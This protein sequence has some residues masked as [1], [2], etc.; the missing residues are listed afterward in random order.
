LAALGLPATVADARFAKPLDAD[1]I[2]RLA[3]NHEVLITVEEGS[4]GG[5]GSF[6]LQYLAGDGLLDR[7]LKV[8]QMVLPDVFIDQDKPEK[9]YDAASLN[10]PHIVATVLSTLGRDARDFGV[11]ER[12]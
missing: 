3:Q 10:A 6:V 4:V 8:R 12:A 1:L 11:A 9:M 5:F 2:R 7:G